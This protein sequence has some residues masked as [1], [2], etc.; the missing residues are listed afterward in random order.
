MDR[1]V[2][3]LANVQAIWGRPVHLQTVVENKPVLISHDGTNATQ[4]NLGEADD[5]RKNPSPP[6]K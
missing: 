4:K 1:A 5:P 2:D 3:T 6:A